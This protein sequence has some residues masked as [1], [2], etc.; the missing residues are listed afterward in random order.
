[1][2][3]LEPLSIPLQGRRLIEASAGTGKTYTLV[4]LFL[5]LMLERRLPVDQ[6]LVVTFTRAATAELRD[7]IRRRLR[8]ALDYIEGRGEADPQLAQLLARL[9]HKDLRQQLLDALT[10][11]DEAAIHTIHGFCQ[12]MLKEHAF[13]AGA[14]FEVELLENETSLSRQIME[15]FWRR[16]FYGAAREEAAWASQ[17]WG[18]P[19]GLLARV[20]G[21]AR[22]L[23]ADL[24]PEVEPGLVAA[25]REACRAQLV[26]L[27]HRWREARTEVQALLATDACLKR[28]DKAYR[29]H[30]RV[31]ELIQAMDRLA[32]EP[33]LPYLLPAGIEKLSP[34]VMA[35]HLAAKCAGPPTHPFFEQFAAFHG[36]HGQLVVWADALLLR[37]ARQFLGRELTVRKQSLG[38]AAYDDLLTRLDAA[39]HNG[40]AGLHLANR[41]A[42]RYPAALIDE[43]QDT[44]QVQYR[45]FT[46]IYHRENTTALF[47]IGDPK[48][49]IYSF[50]GA[51][52]FTYIA[53]RRQTPAAQRYSMATNYRSTPAMVRAVNSLFGLRSEAFVFSQDIEFI[54]VEAGR[55]QGEVLEID[56]HPAAAMTALVLDAAEL[57]TGATL[58][59]SKE[60]ALHA[61]AQAAAAA[62]VAMLS[63]GQAAAV[64][65]HGRQME[66]GDLAVLVRTHREAEA[67][68]AALQ[69]RGLRCVYYSQASVL[70]TA[71]ADTLSLLMTV[72]GDLTDRGLVNTLMATDLFGY[73]APNLLRLR[74]N[75]ALWHQVLE[76][77]LTYQRLWRDQGFSAMLQHLLTDQQVTLR[78]TA[79]PLGERRLTN[80]LHLAELVEKSPAARHGTAAQLRWLHQQRVTPETQSEE[81]LIRLENDAHLIRILTIHRA[82]GLEFPVVILPFLW[83]SRGETKTAPLAFHRRDTFRLT[84]DLG[85]GIEEHRQW[86]EEEQLAEDMRLLYVAM[87]RAQYHCQFCWGRISGME[88]TG[89]GR[90]LHNA[91]MPT[92]DKAL[93]LDLQRLAQEQ[94]D[95]LDIRLCRPDDRRAMPEPSTQAVVLKPSRFRGQIRT[96]WTLTSYTRLTARN[97]AE[98]NQDDHDSRLPRK[99]ENFTDI[100]SFPR[101]SAAGICLHAL[102]EQVDFN[103]PVAEQQPLIAR[104]LEQSGFDRR[105]L[106]A[107]EQW[108]DAV[109]AVPLPGSRPL[110]GLRTQDRINELSF[111][112]PVNTLSCRQLHAVLGQAGI[113]PLA[114]EED[115]QGLMKGF[116]DLVFRHEGRYYLAD[117]KSNYL[118]DTPPRYA[119]AAMAASMDE[120]AYQLQALIYVVALHRFLGARL[121]SYRYT[122][123]FGGMYYLYLRGMHP[124]Y[125]P[126]TGVYSVCPDED[127]VRRLDGC[128]QGQQEE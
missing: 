31:P 86:A 46:R 59:I 19:S 8:E 71:E 22:A 65:L 85:T 73:D 40:Q 41:L 95:N 55:Q 106:P 26:D 33:D 49:A 67:M 28:N 112:F 101:G 25:L 43:F 4:L 9:D 127:L 123:H 88:R 16:R 76:R 124:T 7:R 118:G 21:A 61:S 83:S 13:E 126:G 75:D 92:T 81:H 18:S 52:I 78:L 20:I 115:I 56:G 32:A 44:D 105:W 110:R 34:A 5:R 6:I 91:T 3:V 11:M 111:L 38:V 68:Q 125:P 63:P 45:L 51:D 24:I 27:Q 70:A 108:I 12:R 94:P 60:K 109:L 80:Y 77:L 42:D 82:K 53:A 79:Q 50:R 74:A 97:A 99:T 90:L 119:E 57:A 69:D 30:D 89:L 64:L 47:L 29:R 93:L 116:I 122:E 114:V 120:H 102:L 10:R 58:P 104:C 98:E 100:F 121:S 113:K 72:L 1:M 15:D 54:P 103:R 37:E 36:C 39:L 84:I 107:V 66:P 14:E 23:A 17:T 117:F 62:M 2:Q 96:G 87:T 48:Q 128:F 35:R